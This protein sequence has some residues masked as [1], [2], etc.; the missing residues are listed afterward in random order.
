[1]IT[2]FFVDAHYHHRRAPSVLGSPLRQDIGT[3]KGPRSGARYT[4]RANAHSERCVQKH[5]GRAKPRC[6]RNVQRGWHVLMLYN[7]VFG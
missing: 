6:Q 3:P 7:R 1:M 2:F 4:S 5:V